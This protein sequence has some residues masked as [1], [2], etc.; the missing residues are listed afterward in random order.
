MKYG[1]S[2]QL[3]LCKFLLV[4][5]KPL[6]KSYQNLTIIWQ[7]KPLNVSMETQNF[8]GRNFYSN[9]QTKKHSWNIKYS[10]IM[11]SFGPW[12]FF[13]YLRKALWKLYEF[14]ET[15]DHFLMS[16]NIR[17]TLFGSGENPPQFNFVLCTLLSIFFSKQY[18]KFCTRT[19]LELMLALDELKK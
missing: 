4:L 2:H 19:K 3:T 17:Q 13:F 5:H 18:I 12:I 11:V 15:L 9:L 8:Q 7:P 10:V 14:T 6:F 1:F 16:I